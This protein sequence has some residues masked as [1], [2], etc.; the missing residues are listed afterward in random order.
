MRPVVVNTTSKT[1]FCS[2]N[3][4]MSQC[5]LSKYIPK[6]FNIIINDYANLKE[7]TLFGFDAT[8]DFDAG[9]NAFSQNYFTINICDQ[10]N[11]K[12]PNTCRTLKNYIKNTQKIL[13]DVKVFLPKNIQKDPKACE[14][15]NYSLFLC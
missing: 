7:P 6:L 5:N 1:N 13:S 3:T 2:P 11:P 14:E 4:D 9:A 10:D 15:K 12:Y 8:Q